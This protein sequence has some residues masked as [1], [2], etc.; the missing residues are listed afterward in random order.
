MHRFGFP[1]QTF[2]AILK[3]PLSMQSEHSS[4]T[5]E[6]CESCR[7]LGIRARLTWKFN[8]SSREGIQKS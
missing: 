6:P 8:L 5:P 7:G 1:L 3:G 4:G 2:P